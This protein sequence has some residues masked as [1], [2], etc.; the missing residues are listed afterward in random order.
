[1][2]RTHGV[3]CVLRELCEIE[4]CVCTVFIELCL[5]CELCES[6]LCECGLCESEL[7]E[8]ELC[9]LCEWCSGYSR[10]PPALRDH[11][12]GGIM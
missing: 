10:A 3:S 11:V 1:M 2:D 7:C 8:S 4:L 12:I 9:G 6:E 5:L